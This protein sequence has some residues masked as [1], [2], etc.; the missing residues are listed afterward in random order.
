MDRA[1]FQ[2]HIVL[3]LPNS[4]RTK[5]AYNYS[6][7]HNILHILYAILRSKHAYITH[8]IQYTYVDI[9]YIDAI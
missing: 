4:Y 3:Y 7:N 6:I 9:Q 8:D 1:F 5:L 2:N